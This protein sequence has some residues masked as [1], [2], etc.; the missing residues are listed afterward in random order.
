MS[1][2]GR[3]DLTPGLLTKNAAFSKYNYLGPP[4]A[5]KLCGTLPLC[6]GWNPVTW[7]SLIRRRG[8]P[9]AQ[10]PDKWSCVWPAAFS[11][12]D[13]PC[14]C[15]CLNIDLSSLISECSLLL[16]SF[17]ANLCAG[18]LLTFAKVEGWG[19]KPFWLQQHCFQT[20]KGVAHTV[21]SV[22]SFWVLVSVSEITEVFVCIHFTSH[23]IQTFTPSMVLE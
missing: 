4:E 13:K 3:L 6:M 7:S 5:N 18:R 14:S 23:E 19:K 9:M 12:L 1:L 20:Q 21:H 11:L 17:S 10:S 15:D 16:N 22:L 2:S 8:S